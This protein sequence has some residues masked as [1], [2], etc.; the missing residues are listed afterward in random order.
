MQF[1]YPAQAVFSHIGLRCN[2]GSPNWLISVLRSGIWELKALSTQVA[3]INKE[4]N[5]FHCE[6]GWEDGFF[7]GNVTDS[8]KFRYGSM[9]KVLTSAAI[10]ALEKNYNFPLS[11]DVSN[12]FFSSDDGKGGEVPQSASMEEILRHVSGIRGEVFTTKE[13]PWCPYSMGDGGNLAFEREGMVGSKYSNLGY[14]VLGEVVSREIGG[15][16]R[17]AVEELYGLRGRGITFIDGWDSAGFVKRDFRYND[18]YGP[19]VPARF[20]Y[21]A[22]SSTAGMAGSATSYAKLIKDILSEGYRDFIT[23]KVEGCDSSEI[24]K[25]YGRAFY[26]YQAAS[27]DVVNVKEGYLPG[28]SGVVIINK[29]NEV[30]VWLG[31]S[32]T[33][34]AASGRKMKEF[35]DEVVGTEF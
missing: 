14:C 35:I 32:D 10:L 16:Y 31:N 5:V 27:G 20:D 8:S 7:S 11:T 19:L 24:R 6:S 34:N 21:Y 33:D 9:S 29:K 3:F 15:D 12:Y 2:G 13:K 17:D 28:S 26:V 18:F 1:I 4:G 25:C 23:D 22:I 30:L